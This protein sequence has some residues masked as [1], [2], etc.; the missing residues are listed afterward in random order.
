MSQIHILLVESD[1]EYAR[2]IREAIEEI[3]ERPFD[4]QWTAYQLTHMEDVEDARAVLAAGGVDLVLLDPLPDRP[5]DSAAALRNVAPAV[6]VVMLIEGSEERLARRLLR[7]GIQDYLIK[8]DVDCLPLARAIRK[9]IDRQRY[10]NSVRGSSVFDE[11]TG[12]LNE[13]GFQ[14]SGTRELHLA[15]GAGHAVLLVV[16]AIDNLDEIACA[17]GPSQRELTLLEAAEILRR[18]AGD[19]ALLGA[20]PNGRF[21]ALAWSMRPDDFVSRV[22]TVLQHDP[23][24]F[25]F[26]FGWSVTHPGDVES[27]DP[28]LTSAEACL[29]ENEGAHCPDHRSLSMPPTVSTAISPA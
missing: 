9:A 8:S 27:L 7:E 5:L 19:S 3:Q 17:Y 25:A 4:G 14:C 28:L 10:L 26:R 24:N 11:V 13:Q 18:A 15:A 22:Q 6:P 20:L 1:P 16:A 23:K 21:A 29:C 2:F 12:L